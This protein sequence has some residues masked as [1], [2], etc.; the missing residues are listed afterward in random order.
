[1]CVHDIKEIEIL[2]QDL[3]AYKMVSSINTPFNVFKSFFEVGNRS[4]QRDPVSLD[5][6]RNI[7]GKCF[8]YELNK[9]KVS[10][11]KT[12]PG[13]YCYT[14]F[15]GL[16]SFLKEATYGCNTAALLKVLIPKG[17]K[18]RKSSYSYYYYKADLEVIL[19]E[20]VIPLEVLWRN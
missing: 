10:R 15:D 3:V 4:E 19:A 1:M 13:M 2:D 7:S 12:S 16:D 14:I 5:H 11:F 8:S 20:E 17:S 18:I 6:Y 9:K